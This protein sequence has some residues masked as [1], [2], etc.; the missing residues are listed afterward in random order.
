[1]RAA[2]LVLDVIF[3]VLLFSGLD[4]IFTA[5]IT[6]AFAKHPLWANEHVQTFILSFRVAM[7]WG[8]FHIYYLWTSTYYGGTPAK[9]IF[10]LRVIDIH[11]GQ[12][13]PLPRILVREV[14]GKLILNTATLGLGFFLPFTRP[15]ARALHDLV[16]RSVVKKVHGT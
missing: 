15:D 9:L 12:T 3:L 13:L 5:G 1:V 7:E 2:A 14:F 4:R 16:S 10:G 8:L 11:T 6:L